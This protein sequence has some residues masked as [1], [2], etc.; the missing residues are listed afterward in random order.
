MKKLFFVYFAAFVIG[1][2]TV[3]SCKH[4]EVKPPV[5]VLPPPPPPPA[6]VV[7]KE[8]EFCQAEGKKFQCGTNLW[9]HMDC[10]GKEN[11]ANEQVYFMS[12]ED[13]TA[14]A[15]EHNIGACI[16]IYTADD[17]QEILDYSGSGPCLPCQ[18][19][20]NAKSFNSKYSEAVKAYKAKLAK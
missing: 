14:K 17:K 15:A 8:A 18:P 1:L 3:V 19:M 2:V 9:W 10:S 16:A 4:S 5:V 7:H 13:I 11:E 20:L 6:P 12:K